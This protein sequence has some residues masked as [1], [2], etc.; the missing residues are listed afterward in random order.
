VLEG[1]IDR[2]GIGGRHDLFVVELTAE[3]RIVYYEL[4]GGGGRH[5]A[6]GMGSARAKTGE[7]IRVMAQAAAAIWATLFTTGTSLLVRVGT[8]RLGSATP[9]M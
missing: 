8:L 4:I 2:F 7:A 1:N 3:G 5:G 6:V 9:I